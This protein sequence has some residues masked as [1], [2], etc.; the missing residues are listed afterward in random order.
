[1][2]KENINEEWSKH[3]AE[4]LKSE[5][6]KRKKQDENFNQEKFADEL[7][8]SPSTLTLLLKGERNIRIDSAY[9]IAKAINCSIDYLVGLSSV[10]N[11]EWS[12]DDKTDHLIY[13]ETGLSIEAIN[14]LRKMPEDHKQLLDCLLTSL[15]S[16]YFFDRLVDFFK[17]DVEYG[18]FAHIYTD[19][20]IV[21]IGDRDYFELSGS[22]DDHMIPMTDYE[23][24][25]LS[26]ISNHMKHMKEESSY[27]IQIYKDRI[28]RY[29]DYVEW[30]LNNK[31]DEKEIKHS[32]ERIKEYKKEQES[33]IAYIEREIERGRKRY[34][35]E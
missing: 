10:Q 25:K 24:I 32:R 30:A 34:G 11:R 23:Q 2:K 35:K 29:E 19:D 12:D 18:D 1:M 8:I 17:F 22:V 3:L 31:S 26:L 27:Q 6:G 20:E 33:K 13:K 28:E 5:I 4:V 21:T 7:G 15:G 14:H 16:D 9:N